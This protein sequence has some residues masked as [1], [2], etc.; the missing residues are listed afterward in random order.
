[1]KKMITLFLVLC[2]SAIPTIISASDEETDYLTEALNACNLEIT[3]VQWDTQ[4]LERLNTDPFRLYWFDE[5]WSKPLRIP[6]ITRQM[7]DRISLYNSGEMGKELKI[8]AFYGVCRISGY[9]AGFLDRYLPEYEISEEYPFTNS[10]WDIFDEEKWL[11]GKHVEKIVTEY[12]DQLS[13][14]TAKSLSEF[15]WSAHHLKQERKSVFDNYSVN[16]ELFFELINTTDSIS[17]YKIAEDADMLQL[18]WACIRSVYSTQ[19]LKNI[20]VNEETSIPDILFTVPTPYGRL[21]IDGRVTDSSYSGSNHLLVIDTH[22]SDEYTGCIGA[23]S[24]VDNC[25]SVIIDLTGEDRYSAEVEALPSFGTGILGCGI[26]LD[27]E[28]NDTYV[29]LNNSQGSGTFGMGILADYA[30]D[31]SYSSV[32]L[33]QGAGSFGVGLCLDYDGDD[34]Y[35]CYF[36]SQGFGYTMGYGLLYDETGD[37]EYT[38]NDSD[39]LYPSAQNSNHNTSMSQGCGFGRRA[40]ITD[41]HSMS[42]GCGLLVDDEGDDTY[43][44]GV[45][46]QGVAYWY[47]IGVLSDKAGND[48]YSGL[49]YVQGA[50]AHYAISLFRDEVGDDHYQ[51]KQ[52]TS[53]GV[54]HD[55]SASWHIDTGGNDRYDCW[56]IEKD[57][58]GKDVRKDGG[59]MLGCGNMNGMGFFINVGGDD[60]YDGSSNRMYGGAYINGATS[61]DTIRNEILC[62]GLFLDVGGVDSYGNEKCSEDNS[63]YKESETRPGIEVGIGMDANSKGDGGHVGFIW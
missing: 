3:D 11:W 40:D 18:F 4:K 13:I 35:K 20:L 22:G 62:L 41:G 7:T 53:I 2:L 44:C 39:I 46:G 30:G 59:L 19:N 34:S 33:S 49:W 43:S 55:F 8:N 14:E 61:P 17:L 27:T 58:K 63:W 23:T 57:D 5:I 42:G 28:G 16:S 6:Q 1:M 50:T 32:E 9:V 52:A 10:M 12:E 36:G 45:F 47:A 31:D 25:V 56:R 37:D 26:L 24:S 54:G 60:T 51:A 48:D 21:T 15:M 29:G 38:A